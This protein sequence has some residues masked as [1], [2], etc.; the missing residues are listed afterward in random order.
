MTLG[1]RLRQVFVKCCT[2]TNAMVL[3]DLKHNVLV[4]EIGK[5]AFLK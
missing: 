2:N 5:M 4:D 3:Y 1:L